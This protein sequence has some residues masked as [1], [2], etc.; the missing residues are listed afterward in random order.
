MNFINKIDI[1]NIINCF[2]T[3]LIHIN[4]LAKLKTSICMKTDD[5]FGSMN[6]IQISLN[7]VPLFYA[8]NPGCLTCASLI[9][10][11]FGVENTNCIEL[12]NISN[13]NKL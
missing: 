10:T 3:H 9:A 4:D 5:Y 11:D 13:K 6:H 8:H 12:K 2:D 7:D 1:D